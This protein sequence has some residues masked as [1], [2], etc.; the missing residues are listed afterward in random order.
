MVAL[1][2]ATPVTTPLLLTVAL[3]ASLVDHVPPLVA[4]LNVIEAPA[5]TT[6][7]PV[8]AVT[9]GFGLTVTG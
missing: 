9:V 7:D 2:A 8:I 4:L 6:D 1:P 5:Q 3:V